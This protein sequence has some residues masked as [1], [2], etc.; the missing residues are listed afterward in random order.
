MREY[1]EIFNSDRPEYGG[2]GAVNAA[3]CKVSWKESHGMES[4][5]AIRIPPFGAV[6]LKGQ[7][8]MRAKPKPRK[9]AKEAAAA[10]KPEK[11]AV[12]VKSAGAGKAKGADE[13]AK[14]PV[15]KPRKKPAPA[16]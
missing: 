14:A 6:F 4:S 8:K 1:V 16:K 12:K 13:P 9:K 3:P 2:S 10:E 5:V 15:K 7:G 11:K